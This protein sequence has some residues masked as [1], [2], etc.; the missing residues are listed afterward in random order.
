MTPSA[1]SQAITALEQR[2]G[3]RLLQRTTRSV[4]LTEAGARFLERLRPALAEVRASF[5]ALD[6]L[7]DRPAGTLRL[8]VPR[9]AFEVSRPSTATAVADTGGGVTPGLARAPRLGQEE[10][11]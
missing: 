11:R 2:P 1:V 5:E 6:G 10:R 3:V 8:N 7:R 4:G 9:I